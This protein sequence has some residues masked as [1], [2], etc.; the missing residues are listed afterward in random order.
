MS[1]RFQT[2]KSEIGHMVPVVGFQVEDSDILSYL[3]LDDTW[4]DYR[5][6]YTSTDGDDVLMP[7]VD[8]Y[9]LLRPQGE[10]L[11]LGHVVPPYPAG[12]KGGAA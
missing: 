4:G 3:I 11:K 5:T 9:A 6:Q 1:G 2:P 7:A 10:T 8:F 12:D